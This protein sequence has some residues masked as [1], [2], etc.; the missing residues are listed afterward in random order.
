MMLGRRARRLDDAPHVLP[1]LAP[2]ANELAQCD[3]HEEPAIS[4]RL[5]E[6]DSR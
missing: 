4:L 2:L 6:I 3:Q 5:K 1:P